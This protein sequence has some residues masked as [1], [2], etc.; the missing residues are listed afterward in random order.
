MT[1]GGFAGNLV[2]IPQDDGKTL[3]TD[4]EYRWSNGIDVTVPRWFVTDLAS[5][6]RALPA[7][8]TVLF[9]WLFTEW[10]GQLWGAAVAVFLVTNLGLVPWGRHQFAAVIHDY[11]YTRHATD[12]SREAPVTRAEAD[13]VFYLAMK[14]KGVLLTK[15]LMMWGAVRCFGWMAWECSAGLNRVLAAEPQ[16]AARTGERGIDRA[17]TLVHG[18]RRAA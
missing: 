3:V 1:K 11:L 18:L 8:L 5:V 17:L 14:D 6:P 10:F 12:E 9:T 7:M 2:L 4:R 15:R 13:W 16:G